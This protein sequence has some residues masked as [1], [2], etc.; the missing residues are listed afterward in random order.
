M[1][2]RLNQRARR[3]Y[4]RLLRGM[5]D[6]PC[7]MVTLTQKVERS[8]DLRLRSDAWHVLLTRMRQ[9]WPDCQA[10]TV[11]EYKP[12]CG[13]HLH[14]VVR[15]VPGITEEWVDH[16]VS[17]LGDGTEVTCSPSDRPKATGT[18]WRTT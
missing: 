18:G 10:W 8:L 13:V 2:N 5:Q 3:E 9:R 14:T 17:L 4:V 15:G 12:R 6:A 16:V 7:C 1:T 11:Y